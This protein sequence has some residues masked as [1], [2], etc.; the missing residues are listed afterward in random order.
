MAPAKT[1]ELSCYV[2]PASYNC[3][4]FGV[5]CKTWE[6]GTF[7]REYKP[8]PTKAGNKGDKDDKNVDVKPN[9]D[10]KNA[11]DNSDAGDKKSH[12][13]D[14]QVPAEW[15]TVVAKGTTDDKT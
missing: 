13:D 2:G 1:I 3:V 9:K 11:V 7:W 14:A 15:C 4:C 5:W 10:D 6:R 12:K 8:F